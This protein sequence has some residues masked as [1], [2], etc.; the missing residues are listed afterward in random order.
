MT[1]E[2]SQSCRNWSVAPSEFGQRMENGTS[3]SIRQIRKLGYGPGKLVS[4]TLNVSLHATLEPLDP[5]QWALKCLVE[6]SQCEKLH[7][8]EANELV[9]MLLHP[10]TEDMA[11]MHIDLANR[12]EIVNKLAPHAD[13]QQLSKMVDNLRS[14]S[15]EYA[16]E[17]LVAWIQH[18]EKS[19]EAC[20][21][22]L[23]QPA[24]GK[25]KKKKTKPP[26]DKHEDDGLCIV[27]LDEA[28]SIVYRPC[29]HRVSCGECAAELWTRKKR[30]PWCQ[31]ACEQP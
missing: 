28:R 12:C 16:S 19:H 7:P 31:A 26:T 11:A 10:G 20:Q 30:C 29:G 24:K 9:A 25:N 14:E 8:T 2:A 17:L 22:L 21:A 23:S 15:L 3:P 18:A 27:C 6:A 5:V 1:P 4:T 13:Q